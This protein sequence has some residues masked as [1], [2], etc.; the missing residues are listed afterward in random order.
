MSTDKQNR[1]KRHVADSFSRIPKAVTCNSD[2][3]LEGKG[4]LVILYSFPNRQATTKQLAESAADGLNIVPHLE[5]L[6][7]D[8]FVSRKQEGNHTTWCIR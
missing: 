6:L 3:S 2:L 4:V 8:G 7:R 1:I 5:S